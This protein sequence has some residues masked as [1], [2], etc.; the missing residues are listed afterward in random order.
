MLQRRGETARLLE[1]AAAIEEGHRPGLGRSDGRRNAAPVLSDL[2]HTAV[3]NSLLTCTLD[4]IGPSRL[5]TAKHPVWRLY[6]RTRAALLHGASVCRNSALSTGLTSC[7]Q[8]RPSGSVAAPDRNRRREESACLF[9][10]VLVAPVR[11]EGLV[12]ER[13]LQVNFSLRKQL[14][15][16][17]HP[18]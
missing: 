14:G 3:S 13:L 5:R 18:A 8:S 9:P 12:P 15:A 4:E 6:H 16:A 11:H 2:R 1:S 7:D 10:I 17:H